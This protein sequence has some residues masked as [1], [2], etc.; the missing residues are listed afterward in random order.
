MNDYKEK[1]LEAVQD[2]V[3]DAAEVVEKL[4]SYVDEDSIAELV[5][6]EGWDIGIRNFDDYGTDE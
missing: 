5:D 6:S 1:L 2:G 3:I 4:L